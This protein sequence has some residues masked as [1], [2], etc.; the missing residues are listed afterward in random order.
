MVQAEFKI[1]TPYLKKKKKSKAKGIGHGSS[2]RMLAQNSQGPDF[3]PCY[4]LKEKKEKS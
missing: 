1:T 4:N 3:N 2:G